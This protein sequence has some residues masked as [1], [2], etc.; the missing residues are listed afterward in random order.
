MIYLDSLRCVNAWPMDLYSHDDCTQDSAF[1]IAEYRYGRSLS[2]SVRDSNYIVITPRGS[3]ARVLL[4]DNPRALG[5][6]LAVDS[7]GTL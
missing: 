5:S 2:G 3:S 1:A 4:V 7:T 6:G